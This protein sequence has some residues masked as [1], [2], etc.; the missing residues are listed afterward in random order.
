MSPTEVAR[1]LVELCRQGAY[2]TAQL[3]LYAPD[4]VNIEP[5]GATSP[6]VTGRDAIIAKGRHFLAAMEIHGGSVSDAVVAGPYFSLAMSLDLTPRDGGA[7][8][9]MEEICLYEV[10]DGK[11]VREQFFYPLD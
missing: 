6:N 2:E 4:A 11:I 8:F 5:V 1:R 7:R 3:E 10:R 9:T